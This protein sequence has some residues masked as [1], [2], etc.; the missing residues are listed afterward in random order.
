MD[1]S[2]LSDSSG[3]WDLSLSLTHTVVKQTAHK[4]AR[5][6]CLH[7]RGPRHTAPCPQIPPLLTHMNSSDTKRGMKPSRYFT[8]LRRYQLECL[9]C[10][11]FRFWAAIL[12]KQNRA[13]IYR[14]TCH[15]YNLR[16]TVPSSF[17]SVGSSN[18]SSVC[19]LNHMLK[20]EHGSI[21]I[22]TSRTHLEGV[23]SAS[24]DF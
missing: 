14:H 23:S 22:A 18:G 15:L 10:T 19:T 21:A 6:C 11:S 20:L 17:W 16:I 5:R 2:H 7:P 4:S 8:L 3:I 1:D 9:S 12:G 24:L 13:Q